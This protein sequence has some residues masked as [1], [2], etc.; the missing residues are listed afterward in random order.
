ME[1][2]EISVGQPNLL[3]SVALNP[4]HFQLN[5]LMCDDEYNLLFNSL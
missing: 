1:C 3:F 5:L 4:D 2:Q